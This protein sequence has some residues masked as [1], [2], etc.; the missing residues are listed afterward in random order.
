MVDNRKIG[1]GW[2]LAVLLIAFGV[3]VRG[4]SDSLA[5][6]LNSPVEILQ[7]ALEAYFNGHYAESIRLFSRILDVDATNAEAKKGLKNAQKQRAVQIKQQQAQERNNIYAARDYLKKGKLIDAHNRAR[8]VLQRATELPDAEEILAKTMNN[9]RIALEKSKPESS[10]F[11]EAQGV[12]AYLEQDWFKAVD[13]FQRVLLFDETRLDLLQGLSVAK[14]NLAQQQ[15]KERVRVR[16]DTGNALLQKNL[17]AEAVDVFEEVLRM[18]PVSAEARLGLKEAQAGKRESGEDK[19]AGD[20]QAVLRQAM[21]AFLNGKR[22]T[23]LALFN[24][25]LQMDPGHRV[26]LDYKDRLVG[27]GSTLDSS[28][29]PEAD[30]YQRAVAF[31]DEG[32][33]TEGVEALERRVDRNPEDKR[34]VERLE[35]A[36]TEQRDTAQRLYRESLVAYSQDRMDTAIA[37]LQDCLRVDPQFGL[38]K[39]AMIKMMKEVQK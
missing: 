38:A 6:N 23:A 9:A 25:V 31:L 33:Y 3:T 20:V 14:D 28:L 18:D 37:K 36:R 21:D 11:Y 7:G 24:R 22:D 15:R 30:S 32:R 5:N 8:D 2:W 4:E 10:A 13:C 12:V 17:Y 26:A 1:V 16:L 35:A 29:Q 19:L 39:Q 34:S 27:S